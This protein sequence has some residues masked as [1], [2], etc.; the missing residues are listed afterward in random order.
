M[1]VTFGHKFRYEIKVTFGEISLKLRQMNRNVARNNV[2]VV[3]NE[4]SSQI[5]IYTRLTID[6]MW[7]R[8]H[9]G[10]MRFGAICPKWQASSETGAKSFRLYYGHP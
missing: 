9:R 6:V 4:L 10:F 1:K 7:T 2:N 5:I 3:A 8:R